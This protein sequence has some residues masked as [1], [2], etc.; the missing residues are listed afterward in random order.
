MKTK[1]EI[2]SEIEKRREASRALIDLQK[3]IDVSLCNIIGCN[4]FFVEALAWVLR[5]GGKTKEQILDRLGK[6]RAMY[7]SDHLSTHTTT[8]LNM[9]AADACYMEALV[10]VMD[11]EGDEYTLTL[12]ESVDG[13]EWKTV[14][15]YEVKPSEG[16]K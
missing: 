5:D 3:E 13:S 14:A 2:E 1:K 16:A 12:Q 7:K 10:W 6:R 11:E 9:L 8:S 4:S 15:E